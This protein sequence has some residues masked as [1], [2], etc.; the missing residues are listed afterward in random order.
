VLILLPP[1]E[2][3]TPPAAGD[4]LRLES[5]DLPELTATRERLLRAL[6]TVCQGNRTRAMKRLGLGHTQAEAVVRNARLP[7]EPAARAD[8]VYSGVL[9][10]AW[11]PT[12]LSAEVRKRADESVAVA[13]AL[14]GLVRPG[15]HIPAYRLSSTVTLPRLG[16]V[17]GVWRTRLGPS[18]DRLV[19]GGLLM[20]LRS[21]SYV[22]L[23]R[24]VGDLA[25]RTATIRVL[26]ERSTPGG[27][28]TRTVV[29]H[30]NKATKGRMVRGLL[31]SDAQPRDVGQ[32]RDALGDLGWTVERDD[33]RLDVVV[34]EL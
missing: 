2:S 14:F 20:D 11:D 6:V 27:G 19:G 34:S 26:H 31:E 18:L 23:H 15:D 13:S 3:K 28:S 1:S 8:E 7:D 32:L 5:L 30:F 9:Y 10:A 16:T 12:T 24:P 25:A 33:N 29:S 17:A 4:P 22:N 21:G